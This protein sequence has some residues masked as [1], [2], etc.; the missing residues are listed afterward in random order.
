MKKHAHYTIGSDDFNIDKMT[1]AELNAA[2]KKYA[3]LANE[4]MRELRKSGFESL[5]NTYERF[6]KTRLERSYIGTK[7]MEFRVNVQ[8]SLE[9]RRDRLQF[10]LAYYM[11]PQTDVEAI[12]EYAKMD[13]E[14]LFGSQLKSQDGKTS[15]NIYTATD[16]QLSPYFD[17]LRDIYST[18]RSLGIERGYYDSGSILQ[19]IA[20]II[21]DSS[22]GALSKAGYSNF[23]PS[24]LT[25]ALQNLR[26]EFADLGMTEE[27]FRDYLRNYG[28][29]EDVDG[30]LSKDLS[31]LVSLRRNLL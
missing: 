17:T 24:E 2:I 12:K 20:S 10:I 11:D 25:T 4:R 6:H 1:S 3:P 7:K 27:D 28:K 8:G 9:S 5:S 23:T 15:F 26:Q 16:E 14:Y 18:Y 29:E 19:N 21:Q 31:L 30:E 13:L 22:R